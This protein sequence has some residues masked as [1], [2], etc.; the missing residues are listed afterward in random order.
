MKFT[1]IT[2]LVLFFGAHFAYAQAQGQKGVAV[3]TESTYFCK[4]EEFSAMKANPKLFKKCDALVES[5]DKPTKN[6]D[7]CKEHALAAGEKC[8][9]LS[10]AEKIQVKVRFVEKFGANANINTWT[11]ELDNKGGSACP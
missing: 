7:T 6:G 9:K 2:A 5:A 3:V 1:A 4:I 8:I 11:C 10:K